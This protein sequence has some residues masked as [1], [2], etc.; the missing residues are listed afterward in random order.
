[1]TEGGRALESLSTAELEAVAALWKRERRQFATSF[2]GTSMLPAIA[3]GQ[4]VVV[5]CGCEPAVGDVAV[6]RLNNQVMVHR[7]VAQA[8]KWL[9][10][11]GDANWLPDEPVEASQLIGMIRN[12]GP[13]PR[14][15]L[16]IV[17]PRVFATWLCPV[18]RFTPRIRLAY[19]V[20]FLWKQGV[21]VFSK[22][23]LRALLRRLSPN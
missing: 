19:R 4:Q 8:G 5:Q 14:S 18:E 22:T 20:Q 11:W 10:T 21:L 2:S 17:L 16:R 15:L 13:G 1:V 12:V 23:A 6:F 3:P 9:M 7:V